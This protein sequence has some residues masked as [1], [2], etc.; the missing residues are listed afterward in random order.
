MHFFAFD[1]SGYLDLA[2]WLSDVLRYI[3]QLQVVVEYYQPNE[4]H[5]D[6]AN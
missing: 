2:S 1:E 5:E 3:K 6:P 4:H